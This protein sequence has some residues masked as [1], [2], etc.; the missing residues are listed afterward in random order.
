MSQGAETDIVALSTQSTLS[1][2]GKR[3]RLHRKRRRLGLRCLTIELRETEI[4][5]LIRKNLLQADARHDIFAIRKAL[6]R[7]LDSSLKA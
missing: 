4:D 3:M 5:V 6:Y 1:A 2:A 7:H